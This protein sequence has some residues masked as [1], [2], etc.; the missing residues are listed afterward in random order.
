MIVALAEITRIVVFVHVGQLK[1]GCIHLVTLHDADE[2]FEH[3]LKTWN[4]SEA[5]CIYDGPP[6][7]KDIRR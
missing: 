2:G 1:N 4:E 5:Q 6:T 7:N 3:A